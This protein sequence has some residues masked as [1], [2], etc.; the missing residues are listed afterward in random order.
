MSHNRCMPDARSSLREPRGL[1][2]RKK[3]RTR[4]TIR[5]EAFR[6]FREQGYGATTIEQIAAAADVSPST[7]FRYFPTKEQL[8]IA[9]D[10]DPPMLAAID[11]QPPDVPLFTAIRRAAEDVFASM[12]QAEIDFEQDRQLLMI[13]EP[14]LRR[15]ILQQ[16]LANIDMIIDVVAKRT[17]RTTDDF[18][19]RVVA[20]AMV[21]SILGVMDQTARDITHSLRALEVLEDG[22]KLG[23]TGHAEPR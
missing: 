18:E 9:D 3:E 8:V 13:A 23:R 7:F 2:E 16:L 4:R 21:G 17:G 20:G 5:Q 22:L 10:L 1:R 11:A 14:E 15:A 12:P 6:L 19:V